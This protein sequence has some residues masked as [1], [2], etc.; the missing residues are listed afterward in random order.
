MSIPLYGQDSVPIKDGT[1]Q[2]HTGPRSVRTKNLTVTSVLSTIATEGH[3][4]S[5][6]HQHPLNSSRRGIRTKDPVYT[7]DARLAR[8]TCEVPEA[9]RG[10][11]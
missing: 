11:G 9:A 5:S 1:Y 8:H 7:R 2:T 4:Q 10:V 3:L 6:N